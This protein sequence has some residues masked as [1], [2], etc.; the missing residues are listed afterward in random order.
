MRTLSPGRVSVQAPAEDRS[1][2][3]SPAGLGSLP[4]HQ[5]QRPRPQPPGESGERRACLGK[6]GDAAECRP[7]AVKT[8]NGGNVSHCC[9]FKNITCIKEVKTSAVAV[10]NLDT[11][12]II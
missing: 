3:T 5:E 12:A 9:L 4:S 6:S 2:D 7:Q 1:S 8:A 10:S 11:N